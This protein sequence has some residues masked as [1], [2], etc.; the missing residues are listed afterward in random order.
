MRTQQQRLNY[1]KLELITTPS[2][3][4]SR[5]QVFL[6]IFR[7]FWNNLLMIFISS[8]EPQISRAID[9]KGELYWR[10]L[11]PRTGKLIFCNSEQE[12]RVWMEQRF[13]SQPGGALNDFALHQSLNQFY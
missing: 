9:A 8:D 4:R 10:I 1:Q 3:K 12:I 2:E 13:S 11:D 7:N 6:P 5:A